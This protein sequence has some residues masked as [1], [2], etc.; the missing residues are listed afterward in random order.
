VVQVQGL[1]KTAARF[2]RPPF[3]LRILAKLPESTGPQGNRPWSGVC[4][5]QKSGESDKG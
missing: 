1:L 2:G 5:L 3:L 4:L